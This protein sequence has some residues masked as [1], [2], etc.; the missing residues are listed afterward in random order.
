MTARQPLT[1]LRI[2]GGIWNGRKIRIPASDGLRPSSS[3]LREA[4]FSCLAAGGTLDGLSCL[5]LFAGSGAL[6]LSAAS[7][8]AAR[9]TFVEKNRRRAAALKTLT[10]MLAAPAEVLAL[11]AEK[12][13]SRGNSSAAPR[14]DV[15]FLDPPFAVYSTE[16]AWQQ[17]LTALAPR[18]NA[19]ARVYCEQ[20]H[21]FC[22]PA[23]WRQ[24]TARR[25]G[26]VH[27]QILQQ[28]E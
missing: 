11:P 13:L 24:L 6:G 16:S 26:R 3:R 2:S 15:A 8:G 1:S 9:I 20:V 18:L 22:P 25:I 7:H 19:Q 10:A 23:G 12:F 27:W 28:T 14:F 4:L 21:L 5:D 17:L